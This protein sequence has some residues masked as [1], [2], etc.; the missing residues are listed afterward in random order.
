[1]QHLEDMK[2]PWS[3]LL[4]SLK[5]LPTVLTATAKHGGTRPAWMQKNEKKETIL[6]AWP[7]N[8]PL[9]SAAIVSGKPGGELTPY[10]ITPFMEGV[11]NTLQIEKT[12]D[13]KNGIEGEVG[14]QIDEHNELLWFYD[15][16]YF[17]DKKIDLTE[18]IEQTFYMSGLCLAMRPA[19]LDE[20]TIT[21]GPDYERLAQMWLDDNPGKTRL[22]VPPVKVK[23][24][25]QRILG[26]TPVASEY[27]ARA[28][29]EKCESFEFG[30]EKGEVKVYRFMTT[31]GHKKP[32]KLMMYAPAKV[33]QNGYE[34]KEGDEVD[35]IF[36]L[37][38]RVVDADENQ[39]AAAD[40]GSNPV[41]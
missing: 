34:P 31:F 21:Q 8:S 22:D 9:R 16:L 25:G 19:L 6:L 12:Y 4:E 33:C 13:W 39:V 2:R 1:M 14:C 3:T 40:T 28:I 38:G 11:A 32:M 29:I 41:Q 37:Q 15:P 10:S 35:I 18:G 23:L 30:P 26:P 7:Q 27:Q 24:R 5:E 17:R 20:L 36:W